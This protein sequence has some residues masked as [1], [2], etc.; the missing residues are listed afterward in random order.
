MNI[1][2][3]KPI[4]KT[5]LNKLKD[6]DRTYYPEQGEITRLYAYLT[7]IDKELVKITVA[8][9]TYRSKWFCKQVAVH[10]INSEEG[11][12]RD[13]EYNLYGYTIDW[14]K[15]IDT[16]REFNFGNGKWYGTNSKYY[17]PAARIIN[18][19]LLDRMPEYRY[20]A[21]KYFYSCNLFKFLKIYKD[22]PQV[23]ILLKIGLGQFYALSK[24]ILRKTARNKE[25]RKWLIK[26]VDVINE[27]L[28]NV[29]DVIAAFNNGYSLEY[30]KFHK[31]TKFELS[32]HCYNNQ[33]I[34]KLLSNSEVED[35][36]NYLYKKSIPLHN[37]KDYFYACHQLELDIHDVKILF[38]RD[39]THWHDARIEQLAK[40]KAMED[41]QKKREI[42][43]QFGI[44][45]AKYMPMQWSKDSK[46]V[47]I[48]ASTPADLIREGDILH[49]CVGSSNYDMRMAEERSL[50]FFIREKDNP[51]QPL[52]TL[53]YSISQK[54]VWQFYGY[55]NTKPDDEVQHYVYKQ[56]LPYAN[57]QIKKIQNLAA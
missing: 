22:Y 49:H 45:A 13:I 23:E 33:P 31:K 14:H 40:K 8:V 4:P 53:E 38:P 18:L 27:Q 35:L 42:Y 44:I 25:F 37:Y 16:K 29:S 12:S 3:L 51:D 1:N 48:L 2:K 56:W 11:Y 52:Y 9:C 20:S 30:Q 34:A 21:Y 47:T 41:E 5:I 24:S 7:T 28:P 43:K 55:H 39:F 6:A 26:N 10:G 54:K 57:K 15:E 19:N 46:Y 17:D 32:L 50:I 36:I